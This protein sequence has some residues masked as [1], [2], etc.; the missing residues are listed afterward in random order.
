MRSRPQADVRNEVVWWKG[1][2]GELQA[3]R[4]DSRLTQGAYAVV[5]AAHQPNCAA[6]THL[7]RHEEEHILVLAGRYH[8]AIGDDI[9]D[10][11][12]GTQAIVPRNTPH[13]WRNVASSNSR[14][15]V[16]L[17]PGGFEQI[18]YHVERTPL[19]QIPELAAEY[20]CEIL[21]PP[22]V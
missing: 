6:P 21:G 8:I 9:I 20:G 5:E 14:L 7:H 13:S 4:I 16:V 22:V 17:T 11:Q 12:P 18:V 15:L 19:P 1:V 3:V 2:D 10:A